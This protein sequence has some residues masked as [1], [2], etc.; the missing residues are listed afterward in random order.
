M[1]EA[2]FWADRCNREANALSY[3]HQS[4]MNVLVESEQMNLFVM[5]KP[6]LYLSADNKT[7]QV[8]YGENIQDGIYGSG[9][10][11]LLAI[12]DFNKK[13]YTKQP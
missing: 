9:A 7:W 13:F 5:L 3:E 4:R 10:S 2:E 6:K 12:I 1:T 11:P 8:L